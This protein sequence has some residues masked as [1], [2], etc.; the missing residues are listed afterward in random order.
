MSRAKAQIWGNHLH[1]PPDRLML[2]FC[3]GRDVQALPMADEE[4]LP[5][6]LWTNRAHALMLGK[7][8]IL[9][10]AL[11]AKT[12]GALQALEGEW[13]AGR[14]KLDPA[15]ED[16][17]VNVER[18]VT[19]W[20]GPEAGGRLHTG[21]SRNDQVACDMRLYVRAAL[22]DFGAALAS[23]SREVLRLAAAHADVAMPGFTHTQPAMITTWGHWL[24]SYAQALLRDLERARDAF[25]QVNR[26]PLGAAA[27][28]GT[29]WPIDREFTAELLGFERVDGNTLDAIGSRW[30]HEANA[31]HVYALAMNHLAVMAQDLILLTHPYWG[32][33]RLADAYVTGSSIMPQKRNP[34]FA[35]VIKGKCAWL[36][37][38]VAGLLAL[39]KGGMSGFNRDSQITKYAILDVVRECRAAPLVMQGALASLTVDRKAMA[40]ALAKGF[41]DATDFADAL[42]RELALPFRTAYDIAAAAVRLSGH[43]GRI[44]PE[45]ARKALEQAGH[46]TRSAQRVIADLAD[47]ARLVARRRHTGSPAPD[48]VRAHVAVLAR[49]LDGLAAALTA[50]RTRIDD[51]WERCRATKPR[52]AGNRMR[53]AKAPAWRRLAAPRRA[54]RPSVRVKRGPARRRGAARRAGSKR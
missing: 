35:E 32:M 46:D 10:A 1:Q 15:L 8:G 34:D 22:A 18:Y 42:A 12:L 51:A 23:L 30:E 25:D 26:S 36:G 50:R 9:P 48:A 37:G 31:A 24:C 49:E 53:A 21:R 33:A 44:A 28:F 16:V 19:T 39:P 7:Q 43:A 3:A 45:A 4:L 38:I 6:D 20:A 14:Y 52:N 40:S 11:V 13:E 41:L 17:H 29:S 47:P 54:M 2:E 5:F 27:A